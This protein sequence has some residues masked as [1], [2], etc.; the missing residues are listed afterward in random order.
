MNYVD[1]L[2]KYYF[3][4]KEYLST[5]A[6]LLFLNI[7]IILPRVSNTLNSNIH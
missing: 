7:G 4:N 5:T 2:K 3:Q 1:I 6:A